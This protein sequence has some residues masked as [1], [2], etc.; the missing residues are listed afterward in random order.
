MG[1]N[2]KNVR[3]MPFSHSARTK[4]SMKMG[5][6]LASVQI[7]FKDLRVTAIKCLIQL[8][9]IWRIIPLNKMH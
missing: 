4:Y 1:S 2:L 7:E 9:K 8:A 6:F 5:L 3:N